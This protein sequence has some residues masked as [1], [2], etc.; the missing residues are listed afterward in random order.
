MAMCVS[1]VAR[2]L[3]QF[4]E[5]GNAATHTSAHTVRGASV[6]NGSTGRTRMILAVVNACGMDVMC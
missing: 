3:N 1:C 4:H 6:A 5:Q 2:L